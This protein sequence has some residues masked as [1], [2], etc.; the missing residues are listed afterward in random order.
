[1]LNYK[2]LMEFQIPD[3][4]ATLHPKD[5]MLYALGVGFGS[6]PLESGQLQYV[7][8]NSLKVLP[9]MAT[10]IAHVPGWL[11][12]A[13]VN[14]GPSIHAGCR[15]E[16]YKPI[17]LHSTYRSK[18]KI[19]EVVDKG[20]GKPALITSLREVF[21]QGD[22]D[23]TFTVMS[24]SLFRG[25]GGFGGQSRS[26]LEDPI[27]PARDADVICDLQ[28]LPQQALIYRLSGDYNPL[29]SD[30]ETARR[31]GFPKPIFH[32]LGTFGFACHALLKTLC[33]YEASRLTKIGARF[34][35]PVF[36]G[37]SL[38]INIWND[39]GDVRFNV[40]VPSRANEIVLESGT[41]AVK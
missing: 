38:R 11:K 13:D 31:Q 10:V 23:P 2:K 16:I 24:T 29:H 40:V 19:F 15:V 3:T 5:A 12:M 27:M 35:R 9:T 17:K 7:Q 25:K 14:S 8:E 20:V 37:E 28:T 26:E 39:E 41:A 4:H 32:G 22:S 1:M 34:V 21:E 6:D 18:S 33:N 36:P 30:P